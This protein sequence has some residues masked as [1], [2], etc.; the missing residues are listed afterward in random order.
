M[1]VRRVRHSIA[2]RQ[3]A[4]DCINSKS[5]L[6]V[7]ERKVFL[8]CL[9]HRRKKGEQKIENKNFCF[10]FEFIVLIFVYKDFLLTKLAQK[11][12]LNLLLVQHFSYLD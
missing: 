12:K 9:K 4:I 11:N 2:N 5:I 1:E 3:S 8:F 7:F 6:F 10:L